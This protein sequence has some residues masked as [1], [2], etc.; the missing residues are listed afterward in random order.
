[1]PRL[2]REGRKKIKVLTRSK[3]RDRK[4]KNITIVSIVVVV[5]ISTKAYSSRTKPGSMRIV[6]GMSLRLSMGNHWWILGFEVKNV[7]NK[8]IEEGW[9]RASTPLVWSFH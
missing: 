4:T 2:D 7:G 3:G 9:K 8:R 6:M 5:G 1:L